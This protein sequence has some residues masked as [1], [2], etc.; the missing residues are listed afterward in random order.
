MKYAVRRHN[1]DGYQHRAFDFVI[2]MEIQFSR[3]YLNGIF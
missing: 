2:E 3:I 1:G